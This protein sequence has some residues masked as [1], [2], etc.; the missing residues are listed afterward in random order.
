MKTATNAF[1]ILSAAAILALNLFADPPS[2]DQAMQLFQQHRWAEAASAFDQCEKN[3]PGKTTASLYRG[4]ALVNLGKFDE[5]ASALESYRAAHP[6]SDDAAYLL[7][8]V[9]F[10]QDKPKESLELFTT[11]ARLKNPT[12]DDLK[13]VALDYVLLN[14]YAD[15]ARYLEQS[16]T[17]APG[18]LEARYHLGRVRYQQNRFDLAVAAFEEV[19]RRDPSNV[20]AEDNLGLS[21]EAKNEVDAALAAYRKAVN[22]DENLPAQNVPAEHNAQPYLNLGT[23]LAKSGRLEDAIPPL[24]RAS[25]LAPNSGKAHYQLAKTYFDL[26]R[27]DEARQEAERAVALDPSDSSDHY[28]LGR[29]YQR[30]GKSEQS[31][32]QFRITEQLIHSKSSNSSGMASDR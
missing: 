23:L 12:P 14:D 15:A 13:N 9:R 27:L 11:A 1:L 5:A 31:H 10:R 19:L 22:L 30:S 6:E 26:N 4:K 7:A 24:L 21:L 32:E 16:L 8:Y 29:I 17:A 28:L 2:F 3:T 18:N 25:A 20:K